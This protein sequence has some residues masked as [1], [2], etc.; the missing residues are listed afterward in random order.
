MGLIKAFHSILFYS[1]VMNYRY[2][3]VTAE[4]NHK[5]TYL[6]V[7]CRRLLRVLVCCSGLFCNSD[8]YRNWQKV[9][10]PDPFWLQNV[11]MN[12]AH[13]QKKDSLSI[14]HNM[15]HTTCCLCETPCCTG[16]DFC[17][18]WMNE[19]MDFSDV[20]LFLFPYQLVSMSHHIVPN[21]IWLT[22][23]R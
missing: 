19:W 23:T 10:V 13:M 11:A 1:T 9:V 17:E 5:S 12:T 21:Q 22:V 7:L 2:T 4:F 16:I 18:G 3:A 6:P 15:S 20:F 8:W 14:P